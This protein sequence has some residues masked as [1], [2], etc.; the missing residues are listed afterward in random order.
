M[1]RFFAILW[2][3]FWGIDSVCFERWAGTPEFEVKKLSVTFS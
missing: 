2:F 3:G 1:G